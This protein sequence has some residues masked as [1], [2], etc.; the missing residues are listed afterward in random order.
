MALFAKRHVTQVDACNYIMHPPSH[1]LHCCTSDWSKGCRVRFA[2]PFFCNPS[3]LTQ[4]ATCGRGITT[5]VFSFLM[6]F[7]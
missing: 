5:C 1:M 3:L 2:Q 4:S 6:F 7:V